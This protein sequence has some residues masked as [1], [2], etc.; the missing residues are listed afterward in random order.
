MATIGTIINDDT[1]ALKYCNESLQ[2]CG[3]ETD[4]M[5]TRTQVLQLRGTLYRKA[6]SFD[7]GLTQYKKA[8]KNITTPHV[9]KLKRLRAEINSQIAYLYLSHFMHL[10]EGKKA[11]KYA[12]EALK[13]LDA[14]DTYSIGEKE[15]PSHFTWE[16]GRHRW[17]YAQVQL[18]HF[19]NFKK[20]YQDLQEALYIVEKTSPHNMFIKGRILGTMGITLLRLKN[21]KEAEKILSDSINLTSTVLGKTAAWPQHVRRAEARIKLGDLSGAY[22]DCLAVHKQAETEK[23]KMLVLDYWKATYHAGVIN[24]KMHKYTEAIVYFETFVK[25]MKNFC[26][27]FLS[28]E[29][30]KQLEGAGTFNHPTAQTLSNKE[31]AREYLKKSHII[32]EAIYGAHHPFI[33]AYVRENTLL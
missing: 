30:M 13:I 25:R 32:L 33:D 17:K 18:F 22:E 7:K 6:G 20:A 9:R 10:K 15:L 14:T 24:C 8:L 19:N 1:Q 4:S 11:E 29:N 12:Y 2:I 31:M 26:S 5:I 28:A 16:T 3:T 27:T 21:Y 23:N